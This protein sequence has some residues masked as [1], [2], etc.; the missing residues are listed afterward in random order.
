MMCRSTRA[1][2]AF[3]AR[4]ATSSKRYMNELVIILSAMLL[5]GTRVGK[6]R[7]PLKHA[8]IGIALASPRSILEP[9]EVSTV[10]HMYS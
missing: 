8:A 2:S 6:A 4:K 7:T 9:I 10:R 5:D 3:T 1:Q